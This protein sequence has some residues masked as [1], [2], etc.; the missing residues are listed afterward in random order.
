MVV[1][2]SPGQPS[3]TVAPGAEGEIANSGAWNSADLQF[4]TSMVPHHTQALRMAELAPERASDPRVQAVAER[5]LS[6]Q[7]GE[8]TQLQTW[9][10]SHALPEADPEAMDHDGMTM[11]GM[12]AEPE[13]LALTSS[14]GAE[15]DRL[16]L[17]LMTEHHRG[18]LAMA[19]DAVGAINPQVMDMVNETV[20][21]QSVEIDRMQAVLADLP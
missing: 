2:G 15:F 7:G 19:D 20:A 5:I 11:Q 3:T 14:E 9:L 4:V 16:F 12:A 17:E 6:V 1:P 21:G 10:T 8:V 13:L 18:A